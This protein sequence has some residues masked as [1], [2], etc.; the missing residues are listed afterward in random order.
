MPI[1]IKIISTSTNHVTGRQVPVSKGEGAG[2][3]SPGF[4]LGV[5]LVWWAP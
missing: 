2:L 5:T 3:H 1:G 4:L